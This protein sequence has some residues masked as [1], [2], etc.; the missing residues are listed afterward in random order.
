MPKVLT[1]QE[2]HCGNTL[3]IEVC[4]PG[5]ESGVGWGSFSRH[6]GKD[7][8]VMRCICD[9]CGVVFNPDHSRF[10]TYYNMAADGGRLKV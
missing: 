9:G 10:A 1:N 2:C 6:A 5:Q 4:N 8:F 3:E 7:K